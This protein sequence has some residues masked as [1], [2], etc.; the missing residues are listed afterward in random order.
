MGEGEMRRRRRPFFRIPELPNINLNAA[1]VG[2]VDLTPITFQA[3]FVPSSPQLKVGDHVKLNLGPTETID[4]AVVAIEITPTLD[5]NVDHISATL[6][7]VKERLCARCR[8]PIGQIE[9]EGFCENCF[10]DGG[11]L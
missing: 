9:V 8:K 11:S 7:I 3:M 2:E 10:I 4:A 6:R 1:P 5:P